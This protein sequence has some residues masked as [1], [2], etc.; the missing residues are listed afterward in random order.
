MDNEY[1]NLGSAYNKASRE[2]FAYVGKN[3]KPL[4]TDK[5]TMIDCT[6]GYNG[7]YFNG[8]ETITGTTER[9]SKT[10]GQGFTNC[11]YDLFC[12]AFPRFKSKMEFIVTATNLSA[13]NVE[14]TTDAAFAKDNTMYNT[15]GTT[16]AELKA[17]YIPLKVN[18]DV[19]LKLQPKE[20]VIKVPNMTIKYMILNEDKSGEGKL[21]PGL[22]LDATT[23]NIRGKL[24]QRGGYQFYYIMSV[25][26][27]KVEIFQQQKF[28]ITVL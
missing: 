17:Y 22:K 28:V 9:C 21:P 7:Y 8:I 14:F 26:H 4:E 13:T 3:V 15:D 20:Y 11:K 12:G 19:S 5:P 10:S 24:S 18:T 1:K 2:N 16:A 23:G 27:N 6:S 25:V